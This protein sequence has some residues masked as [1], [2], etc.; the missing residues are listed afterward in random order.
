MRSFFFGLQAIGDHAVE[1]MAGQVIGGDEFSISEIWMG[2]E[3]RPVAF[4]QRP[5]RIHSPS[6]G[7]QQPNP[8]DPR[9]RR[10]CDGRSRARSSR[11]EAAASSRRW[12]SVNFT[13]SSAKSLGLT[14][15]ET[16]LATAD[17]VIQ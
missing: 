3:Q 9:R 7:G 11:C 2:A 8:I 10:R 1:Q 14:I 16:L 13:E 6:L 17:E 12:V 15:P 5:V 4:P